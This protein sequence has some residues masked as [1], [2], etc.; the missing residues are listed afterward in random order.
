MRGVSSSVSV[1]PCSV[2]YIRKSSVD[3]WQADAMNS[4]PAFTSTCVREGPASFP[5]QRN[6]NCGVGK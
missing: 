1:D 5:G 4:S 3:T 2:G 6:V